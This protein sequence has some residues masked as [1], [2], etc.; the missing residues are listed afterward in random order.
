MSELNDVPS[1]DQGAYQLDFQNTSTQSIFF[2]SVVKKVGTS[3]KI[4]ITCLSKEYNPR[5]R[6]RC[7]KNKVKSSQYCHLTRWHSANEDK[8]E[9]GTDISIVTKNEIGENNPQAGPH[10]ANFASF[11]IIKT[12]KTPPGKY[13]LSAKTRIIWCRNDGRSWRCIEDECKK[14]NH[15]IAICINC[16]FGLQI[17]CA[18]KSK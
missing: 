1:V 4:A 7:C 13:Y 18:L 15:S 6:C 14:P 2:H 8:V 3:N 9:W 17:R 16:T 10:N 11:S 12:N 5:S